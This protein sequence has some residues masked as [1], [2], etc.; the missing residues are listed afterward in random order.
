MS[1]KKKMLNLMEVGDHIKAV[2][3]VLGSGLLPEPQLQQWLN[4]TVERAIRRSLGKSGCPEWERWAAKWLSGEDRTAEAAEAAAWEAGAAADAARA[5]V[6]ASWVARAADAAGAA[7]A[8]RA[9]WAERKSQYDGL[10]DLIK[11]LDDKF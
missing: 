11:Q 1:N 5:A 8:A 3:A 7:W 9:A 6:A 10:L 2:K 4:Q